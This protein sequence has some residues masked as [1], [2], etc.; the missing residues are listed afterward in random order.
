MGQILIDREV[1]Q[2]ALAA[3]G[4][5]NADVSDWPDAVALGSSECN[6]LVMSTIERWLIA[7]GTRLVKLCAAVRRGQ[8]GGRY[9]GES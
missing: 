6:K 8:L 4:Y 7:H 5:P 3:M 9:D 1:A 2:Q